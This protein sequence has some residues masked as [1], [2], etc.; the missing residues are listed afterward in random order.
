M[1]TSFGRIGP[2]RHERLQGR[3]DDPDNRQ[4]ARAVS[5][6]DPDQV[7][8]I[9]PSLFENCQENRQPVRRRVEFCG[10]ARKSTL[11]GPS[12][13]AGDR[14]DHLP[15]GVFRIE[16]ARQVIARAGYRR[17]TGLGRFV[18]GVAAAPA[19]SK[20]AAEPSAG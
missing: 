14:R 9:E 17:Q 5:V 6:P 18:D 20:P 10:S 4:G 1:N 15:I 8:R 2:P 3:D 13:G 16:R 11:R 19:G 12:G 7:N